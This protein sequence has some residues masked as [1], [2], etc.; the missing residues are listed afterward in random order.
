ME[1]YA[2]NTTPREW[3]AEAER[4]V[5]NQPELL[6]GERR[7]CAY[8]HGEQ[9]LLRAHMVI[10]M[11]GVGSLPQLRIALLNDEYVPHPECHRRWHDIE[12]WEIKGKGY[13]P[14]G[15][16]LESPVF[17]R[18]NDGHLFLVSSHHPSWGS[19]CSFKATYSVLMTDFFDAN[20]ALLLSCNFF[21]GVNPIHNGTFTVIPHLKGW[22]STHDS[23]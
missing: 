15:Q 3:V 10:P 1:R 12:P 11:Q 8:E 2:L 9:I 18:Q 16:L 7:S 13:V 23:A 21:G 20:D 19:S 14:G 5:A 22:L 4:R 17:V 6:T